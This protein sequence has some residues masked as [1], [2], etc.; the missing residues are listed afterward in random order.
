MS[1]FHGSTYKLSILQ[2]IIYPISSKKF[3]KKIHKIMLT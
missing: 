2:Y 3:M 1:E